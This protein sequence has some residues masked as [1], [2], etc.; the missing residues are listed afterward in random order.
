MVV[1]AV[2]FAGGSGSRMKTT[3][4]PKQFLEL[5]GKPII[6]HTIEHFE[7]HPLVD[8]IVIVCIEGWIEYLETLLSKFQIKKVVKVVPGGTTGQMSIFNGLEALSGNIENDDIVLIHDGV[9]PL[10]DAEIITNNIECVR[11][12]RTAITVKPVI[13]TVIQVNEDNAITNVVDRDSCQTAV[14]PQSFYLS[15]IYSLHL[16]AQEDGL[17]N[18]TDSATLVRHYGLDLFTVMGGPENIKIT[19]P[20]DFYIFRAIYD[21]RENAQIFG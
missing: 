7:N 9:R 12:N 21:S 2:I 10:I 4:K 5:H 19:T 6:I 17:I 13:E 16:K 15:D 3:T 20:S 14:A 11:N 1:S 8:Q 18:M